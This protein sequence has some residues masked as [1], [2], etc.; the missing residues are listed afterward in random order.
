MNQEKTTT[1]NSVVLLYNAEI[2]LVTKIY[3]NKQL[4]KSKSALRF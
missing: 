4:R 1:T 2:I 3:I